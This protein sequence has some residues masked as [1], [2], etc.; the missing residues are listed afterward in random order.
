[1]A[2]PRSQTLF[3]FTSKLEY[4]KGILQRGFHPRY[5]L[6]DLNWIFDGESLAYPM[7]C[8]CDIP[9]GR[10]EQHV[11]G[12]GNYGIGMSR[13]WAVEKKLNP[14]IYVSKNSHL[15]RTLDELSDVFAKADGE[16]KTE[17]FSKFLDTMR[18]IKPLTGKMTINGV[19]V[20]HIDFYQESEWRYV[21]THE[22]I[23]GFISES[24]WKKSGVS[25]AANAET[26]EHGLLDFK[27]NDIRYLF[28]E[29]DSDIPELVDFI[30]SSAS[31]LGARFTGDE[32]K[33]LETR[34]ISQE[35]LAQDL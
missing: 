31:G 2:R 19:L 21:P 16:I 8:F 13:A 5:C 6:E 22:K 7:V 9:L 24:N 17:G 26:L 34:I 15:A 10:V 18:Y 25:E 30:R 33:I 23:K 3:H 12:Y 29:K 11:G 1:M 28:V 35:S 14:V 20:D 27:A 4:L 32:I